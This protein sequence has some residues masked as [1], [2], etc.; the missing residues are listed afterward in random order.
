MKVCA[1]GLTI[2]A[3]IHGSLKRSPIRTTLVPLV[4]DDVTG[5]GS[6]LCLTATVVSAGGVRGVAVPMGIARAGAMGG[7]CAAWARARGGGSLSL[8]S[9]S[10]QDGATLA[11][12]AGS[13]LAAGPAR[14]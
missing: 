4:L 3:R 7:G 14:R 6:S 10:G 2:M 8:L 12:V 9:V 11:V 5:G 1:L 13:A